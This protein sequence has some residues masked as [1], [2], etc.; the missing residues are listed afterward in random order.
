MGEIVFIGLGLFDEKDISLKGLGE[1]KDCDVLF[2]EFYTARLTGCSTSEIEN[3]IGKSIEILNREQFE[4]G[5]IIIE[6]AREKKV[7]V[8]VAGDSMSATTHVSLRLKAKKEGIETRIIPGASIVTSAPGLCGLH[9]YK[10]G[11]I[12]SLPFP[13]EGYFPTS[14]YEI[15]Q[16]NLKNGMHTLVLLDIDEETDRFMRGGEALKLLLRMEE[17]M[18]KGIIGEGTLVCVLG[19]VGS[20]NPV[21]RAGYLKSLVDEDFGEGLNCLVIPGKLHFVE[22]EALVEL[23]GA[24]REILDSV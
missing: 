9:I 17:E 11:R 15:I 8:L 16:E 20:K 3:L 21:V 13:K 22:A 14:P 10:F 18:G 24:P 6:A 23:G 4:K 2:A 5:D 1:A 7:G 19:S 12:A